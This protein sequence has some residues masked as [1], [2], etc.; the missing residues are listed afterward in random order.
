MRAVQTEVCV[1]I[2]VERCHRPVITVVAGATVSAKRA[3]MHVVV[4][5]TIGTAVL[6]IVKAI[7]RVTGS[8]GDRR[9]QTDQRKSGEIMIETNR[10]PPCLL[11]MTLQAV[12]AEL[13]C[14]R[15]VYSV[16]GTAAVRH[17]LHR[18]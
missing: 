1:Q 10:L 3:F 8:A 4:A 12:F 15:V 17:G 14:V 7:A 9:M 18:R 11:R 2:V 16:A 5:V 13:P 6:R